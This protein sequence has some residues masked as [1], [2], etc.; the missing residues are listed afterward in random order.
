MIF[1]S[2]YTLVLFIKENAV[3]W[4]IIKEIIY[5]WICF[6]IQEYLNFF[7]F[8]WREQNQNLISKSE[9]LVSHEES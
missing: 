9:E 8:T 6:K 7:S 3:M 5:A 2:F 4:F 1:I